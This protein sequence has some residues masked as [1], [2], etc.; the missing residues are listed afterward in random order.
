[1][2]IL[3]EKVRWW[4]AIQLDIKILQSYSNRGNILKENDMGFRNKRLYTCVQYTLYS[5]VTY[6]YNN[7]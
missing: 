7:R 5:A 3:K 4:R 6:K 2:T 1:M